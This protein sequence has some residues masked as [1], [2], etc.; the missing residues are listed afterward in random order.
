VGKENG[1]EIE[2]RLGAMH[3]GMMKKDHHEEIG[4]CLMT[5]V[6]A[7]LVEEIAAIAMV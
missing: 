2:V 4:T 3:G 6:E 5:D 1:T 7:V